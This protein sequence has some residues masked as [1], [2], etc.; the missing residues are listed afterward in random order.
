[1]RFFMLLSLYFPALF[2]IS[3][4]DK[5]RIANIGS[6]GQT[7][8]Y[9]LGKLF[10][11][12]QGE[13]FATAF[14]MVLIVVP[15][16][17]ALHYMVIGPKSFSHEG[18][19][20]FVFPLFSR[21]IHWIAALA[22]IMLVPTGFIIMFGETFGGGV[23]VRFARYIHDIGTVLFSIVIIPMFFIWVSRMFIAF[24]D[25]K[26]LVIVGGYLSRKKDPVPSGKFNA[27]QKTWFWLAT[28]GGFVMI[29]TGA[30][31]F[32]MDFN[33]TLI[34]E[35]TGLSHLNILRLS[36]LIHSVVGI[37]I[38]ALFFVHLYMSLF[39]IKGSLDSMITGYK[40]EE[41]VKILHSSWYKEL[42][43]KGEV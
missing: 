11:M 43:T 3:E 23:F 20:I 8:T 34:Q 16:L 37:A 10:T 15:A 30:A 42:K 6:F 2:A 25:I 4:L 40:H 41:E 7:E 9:K 19:K 39:A 26:W 33:S 22:F 28:L 31:M 38:V 17:F 12:L 5:E 1:M 29:L 24:D 36:A 35:L 14:L 18:K 27:G 13:Y 21:I 32:F